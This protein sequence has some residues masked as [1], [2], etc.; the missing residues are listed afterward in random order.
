MQFLV[1]FLGLNQKEL[2][3]KIIITGPESSGKTT[4]CK[5]LSKHFKIPFSKEYAREYLQK[6][7]KNYLQEDL[8]KIA[9]GQLTSERKYILLDTDLITIK[10]WSNYKYGSC[11]KWIL[12]KIENQKSEN[13][14]YLLCK[15]DIE[16]KKDNLRENPKNRQEL[17]KIYKNELESLKHDFF[18]IEGNNR[19]ENAISKIIEKNFVI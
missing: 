16:W 18:I 9:K 15:P 3:L 7:N 1:I 13:R 19:I 2:M 4:L 11:N 14:F 8:V 10:V 12:E 5:S 6:K 17:F